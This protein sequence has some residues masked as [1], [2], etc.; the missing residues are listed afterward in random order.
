MMELNAK[1][2]LCFRKY[3]MLQGHDYWLHFKYN[4]IFLCG[5]GG[6]DACVHGIISL[7]IVTHFL[8]DFEKIFIKKDS[9]NSKTNLL[10]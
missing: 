9:Y 2:K 3:Q 10:L 7:S 8:F 1:G 4:I 6:W 5:F